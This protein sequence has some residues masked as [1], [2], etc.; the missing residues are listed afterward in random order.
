MKQKFRWTRRRFLAALGGTAAATGLYTWRWEPHWLQ[1]VRR[2]LPIKHLP[3]QLNGATLAQFSDLHIGPKVDDAYLQDVFDRVRALSPE[4]V[5]YTGDWIS[6]H[7][8]IR[9]HFARIVPQ[10]ARGSLGTI[11]IL[12]NHDYGVD[13]NDP[14]CAN[15]VAS[16]AENAGVRILQNESADVHG[17]TIAGLDDIWARR[18]RPEQVMPS[19]KAQSAS[20]VLIHNPDAVDWAGWGNYSGWILAGHTHGGQCKPP[21]LPPPML[22][23]AN[24]RYTCG[25]FNLAD[26]RR[27]YI[28][29]GVGH[30]M[31]VRFN[32]RPEV[33]L[34][35]LVEAS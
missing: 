32:V 26:G 20:L 22:P 25:E 19:L 5:V 33:T 34:F 10:V 18:F 29:R 24:C 11:G 31:R 27:L 1:I 28:N 9:N 17:L 2:D 21:F 23:V 4:I 7:S 12:G 35:R 30:L 13:W 15:A 3:A 6:Y 8:D 16:L 14:G